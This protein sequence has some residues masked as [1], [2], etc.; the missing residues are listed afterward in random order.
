MT[1]HARGVEFKFKGTARFVPYGPAY[2][3]EEVG[4]IL[5][6]KIAVS[7]NRRYIYLNHRL[8]LEVQFEDGR[9]FYEITYKDLPI[10]SVRHECADDLYE[11]ILT[12]QSDLWTTE[13]RV[14]G[15]RKKLRLITLCYV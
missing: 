2:L 1:D 13:W 6:A 12:F 5:G 7:A 4:E 15:P 3:Y 8:K 11:G 14:T 9:K 10:V